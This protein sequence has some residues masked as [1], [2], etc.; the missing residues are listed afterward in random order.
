MAAAN[1]SKE[2]R[3]RGR[4]A[5]EGQHLVLGDGRLHK[6]AGRTGV[7]RRGSLLTVLLL[8]V[9]VAVTGLAIASSLLTHLTLSSSLKESVQSELWARAGFA[10]FLQRA[11]QAQSDAQS[12]NE[13]RPVL[14]A[15][16]GHELLYRRE[17][18]GEGLVQVFLELHGSHASIDNSSQSMAVRSSF[19]AANQTSVPPFCLDLVLRVEHNGRPR[20]FEAA[21]QQ[22]W[23]YALA[24]VGPI[25][26]PG[27]SEYTA[28]SRIHGR[29][30]AL[31][32]ELASQELLWDAYTFPRILKLDSTAG[33]KAALIPFIGPERTEPV[34]QG[35]QDGE[36]HINPPVLRLVPPH[37]PPRPR[38][39]LNG[40]LPLN[41]LDEV[42]EG[43]RVG[44]IINPAGH[45]ETHGSVIEG[46]VD[47]CE[48]SP[49]PAPAIV[50]E[51]TTQL[52]DPEQALHGDV[53]HNVQWGGAEPGSSSGRARMAK[54]V[55]VPNPADWPYLND[56]RLVDP[57]YRTHLRLA[58]P[59]QAPASMTGYVTVPVPGG[60]GRIQGD[61]ILAG[62]ETQFSGDQQ[63]S[64]AEYGALN[65]DHCSVLVNGNLLLNN[66]GMSTMNGNQHLA[67]TGT[68][69]LVVNGLLTVDGGILDAGGSGLVIY[70]RSFVIRSSGQLNGLLIAAEGGTFT[71]GRYPQSATSMESPF[72]DQEPTV[73]TIRGGLVI[74]ANRLQMRGSAGHGVT[75]TTLANV[76]LEYAPEYLHGLNQFGDLRL[77]TMKE[78]QP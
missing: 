26:I 49:S 37:N 70:C 16:E 23:P 15:F 47:L 44:Y 69:T 64:F 43:D 1:A 22:V 35:S 13:A 8:T 25:V 40:P 42:S 53:H 41:R 50:E 24:A 75:Q 30:L 6:R 5:G 68:G 34:G 67:L 3:T 51:S 7:E 11:H 57:P 36:D 72:Q 2:A 39:S 17:L 20:W 29:V 19:D 14:S 33:L 74:G 66:G 60:K 21:V 61:L 4:F 52:S 55:E 45:V 59:D 38:L 9:A 76:N 78:R 56:P 62:T 71:T 18:E 46:D 65:I 58:D 10:G 77:L 73:L 31:Q 48:N 27:G 12:L 28:P 63:Y 54:I 32:S